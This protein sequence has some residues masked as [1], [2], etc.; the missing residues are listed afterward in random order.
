MSALHVPVEDW[1]PADLTTAAKA[2]NAKVDHLLQA[3]HTTTR[4]DEMRQLEAFE[5]GIREA[6]AVF[7][8]QYHAA[9]EKAAAEAEAAIGPSALVESALEAKLAE[10]DVLDGAPEWL[11]NQAAGEPIKRRDA[12][13]AKAGDHA[14]AQHNSD[15]IKSLRHQLGRMH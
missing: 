10:L 7:W 3:Y 9:A 6:T 5:L 13:R 12:L 8:S 4:P 1:F 14:Q 15:R 11:R 2:L